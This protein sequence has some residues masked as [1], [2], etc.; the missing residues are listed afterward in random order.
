MTRRD[1]YSIERFA[2]CAEQIS[3]PLLRIETGLNFDGI[4]MK[5]PVVL[6]VACLT[7]LGGRTRRVNL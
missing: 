3:T 5:R 6:G 1:A 4:A 2:G 7:G